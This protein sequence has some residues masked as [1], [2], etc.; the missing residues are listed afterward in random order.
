MMFSAGF[1]SC[2]R[3]RIPFVR[4]ALSILLAL[5]Y[6]VFSRQAEIKVAAFQKNV[7][8]EVCF[9]AVLATLTFVALRR[10]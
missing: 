9:A 10:S 3:V 6:M 1:M 4:D 7:T 2:Q 5:Y 8:I